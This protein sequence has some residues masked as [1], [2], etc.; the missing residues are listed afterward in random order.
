MK[1][2]LRKVLEVL[3]LA[4]KLKYELRHSWLSNGRQESVAEHTWRMALMGVLLEPYLDQEIDTTRMLKMVIV[5]DLVEAE[6][7]DI[8]AFDITSTEIKELKQQKEIQAIENL[9]TQLGSAIGQHI[10]ELWH[11]FEEK[12]TYEAKVANA[13]DKLEVQIQHNHADM[14]TWLEIEQEFVFLMGKHTG[15]DSCLEQLKELI[16]EDAVQKME[17]AGICTT[18]VKARMAA[19]VFSLN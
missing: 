15:F 1:N 2:E 12:Q 4:E 6:A 3:A 5:H 8:P 7:G 16:E 13:L 11:E 9:R 17:K 10:Y 19:K 18:S 14:S